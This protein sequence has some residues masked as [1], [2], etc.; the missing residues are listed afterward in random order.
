[1]PL[2]ATRPFSEVFLELQG[3]GG[4]KHI[5]EPEYH[6]D[7]YRE[8]SVRASETEGAFQ[9]ADLNVVERPISRGVQPVYVDDESDPSSLSYVGMIRE[10]GST[11]Q[12]GETDG[13]C[14][15]KSVAI[16]RGFIDFGVAR[17]VSRDFFEKKEK[18]GVCRGDV[19]INSTGDG[20]IG[21]VA[22]YNRDHPAVVDGHVTI[23]RLKDRRMSWYVAAYL[24]S[25]EGQH[26]IY[27]YINGSSGQV[28]IYPQDIGR[29]WIPGCDDGAIERIARQ[30]EAAVEK[31]DEFQQ[32]LRATL[33]LCG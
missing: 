18:A 17:S 4:R 8:A 16:R 28:E 11:V 29:L 32:E 9:L 1:M 21:R 6:Q 25:D 15:L 14:A 12:D 33:S 3:E 27:R 10:D 7:I 2:L 20:T 26:Q 5:L 24:L 30:F 19:L 23:V 31:F 22:V 13:I